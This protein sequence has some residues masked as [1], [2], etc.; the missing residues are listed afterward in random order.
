MASSPTVSDR[1]KDAPA[2]PIYEGDR[3]AASAAIRRE[4]MV[5]RVVTG[6]VLGVATWFLLALLGIP[7]VVG[8]GVDA[9]VLPFMLV[10][11]V[12]GAT[13]FCRALPFVPGALLLFAMAVGYTSL[14]IGPTRS[15][16]RA[17]PIPQS[18][19]AIV[20]L[21]G[22]ITAD[23]LLGQQGTDRLRKALEL[24][25]AG[26]APRL[27]VTLEARRSKGAVLT[28]AADQKKLAAM[29]G[30]TGIISTGPVESTHDEALAI[31]RLARERGWHRVVVVTSPFHSRRA[32]RTFERTGLAVSCVPSDSR[33]IAVR[34]LDSA[35]DRVRAFGMLLYETAGTLRYRQMGWI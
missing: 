11:G 25:R 1:G 28:S 27:V 12:L 6:A 35:Y 23:G 31:E 15:L 5:Q 3:A 20:A 9:G 18:A 30:V 29:A 7:Q 24:A 4:S 22:G 19:D 32:C 16:I 33:D 8:V 14:V 34:S 21:S 10:G 13:R 17:D 26:V 2:K